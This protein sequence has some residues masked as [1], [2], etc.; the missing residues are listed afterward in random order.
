M[1]AIAIKRKIVL[2]VYC[3]LNFKTPDSFVKSN[4]VC[5]QVFELWKSH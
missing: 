3:N 1:P 5:S 2:V 4:V